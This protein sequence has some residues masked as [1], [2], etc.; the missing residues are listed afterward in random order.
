M[1]SL[2][3][4]PLLFVTS[5]V[6]TRTSAC[7]GV[8]HQPL[9]T[10]GCPWLLGEHWLCPTG[11]LGCPWLWGLCPT[12]SLGCP[13]L[14]GLCPTGSLGCP[15][16]LGLCPTGS[17]GCP[18]LLGLCPMGS[19]G[20]RAVSLPRAGMCQGWHVPGTRLLA[21]SPRLARGLPWLVGAGSP[22]ESRQSSSVAVPV[23]PAGS[24]Q[25]GEPG[26]AAAGA[27]RAPCPAQAELCSVAAAAFLPAASA[28]GLVASAGL[29]AGLGF[30]K[31]AWGEAFLLE[32]FQPTASIHV[33]PASLPSLLGSRR[34][35]RRG[36]AAPAGRSS[37]PPPPP[38][39]AL[40]SSSGGSWAQLPSLSFPNSLPGRQ[41]APADERRGEPVGMETLQS[42]CCCPRAGPWCSLPAG[43]GRE[44]P[45]PSP[46]ALAGGTEQEWE[47]GGEELAPRQELAGARLGLQ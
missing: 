23:S 18:W 19:L 17:L 16:L 42:C 10:L 20:S 40:V 41:E 29:G 37:V 5:S 46:R 12:G 36:R 11:S 4:S 25:P 1:C 47:A 35:Q 13:W 27:A 9:H 31:A 22:C 24:Q 38:A 7:P 33:C 43:A 8:C 3:P 44:E 45:L 34:S 26:W 39:P 14:L 21:V 28:R 6:G 32:S 2:I 30:P 15:W